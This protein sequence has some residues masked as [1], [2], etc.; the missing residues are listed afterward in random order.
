MP[1]RF[2]QRC[3]KCK[4]NMVQMYS[5]KQ[6][7]ICAPCQLAEINQPINEPAMKK[8]FDIPYA[9]YEQSSFL[10][11]IKSNYLKFGNLSPKQ[12]EMFVKVVAELK[13]PSAKPVKEKKKAP[14][15]T[16]AAALQKLQ[17]AF[18]KIFKSDTK[19][20]RRTFLETVEE[21]KLQPLNNEKLVKVIDDLLER[22]R[23][24]PAALMLSMGELTLMNAGLS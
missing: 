4:K 1:V 13:N 19:A 15:D 9:L 16:D 21:L 17:S 10:R 20:Q 18:D 5:A 3:A 8:F 24:R 6:F 12:K 14:A 7:P 11:S 23:G 2:Q 22:K